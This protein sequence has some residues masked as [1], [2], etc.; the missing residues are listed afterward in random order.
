MK[1]SEQAAAIA[2]AITAAQQPI[3]GTKKVMAYHDPKDAANNRPCVLVGLPTAEYALTLGDGYADL[4]WQVYALSSKD[5][6]GLA[7]LHELEDLV[8]AVTHVF[9]VTTA[10][11][12]LYPIGTAKV[13]C[14]V[15][16]V[17]DPGATS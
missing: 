10:R 15:L 5:A 8:A 7:S 1:W 14:Y 3:R 13:P 11:P 4:T 17:P 2:A 12:A 9:D 16:T 6:N